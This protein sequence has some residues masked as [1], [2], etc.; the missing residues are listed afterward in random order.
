[1][2]WSDH[3]VI[4]CTEALH[5]R[6]LNGPTDAFEAARHFASSAHEQHLP[7]IQASIHPDIVPM[8]YIP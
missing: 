2:L 5:R 7:A 4:H 6:C 1:M 8:L 3:L